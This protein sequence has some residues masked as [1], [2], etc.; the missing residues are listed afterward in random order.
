MLVCSIVRGRLPHVN[1]SCT[2]P[3]VFTSVEGKLNFK[4]APLGSKRPIND[5]LEENQLREID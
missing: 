5:T 2:F 4:F 1:F 3:D